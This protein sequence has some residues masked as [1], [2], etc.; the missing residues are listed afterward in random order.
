MLILCLVPVWSVTFFVT[1]DGPCHL[2]N[3]KILLDWFNGHNRAFYDPFYFINTNF[4]PNWLFNLITFPLVGFLGPATTD[5]FFFTLYVAGFG[6]GFRFLINQMNPEAKFISTIGLLFC[7]HKLL[8]TGFL[9]NSL[10]I[11][12]WFWVAGWWWKNRNADGYG[13]ILIQALLFLVL[14]SSHPV[15]YI[16][17]IV[18]ILSMQTGLWFYERKISSREHA[19]IFL[20]KRIITTFLSLLPSLVLFF[21]YMFRGSW[22]SADIQHSMTETIK[23]V[24]LLKSL[25]TIHSLEEL[26][27]LLTSILTLTLFLAAIWIRIKAKKW[28]AADGLI[29]FVAFVLWSILFPPLSLTGGLEISFRLAIIPFIAILFWTATANF[30]KWVKLATQCAALAIAVFFL[31][32]RI[33]VHKNASDYAKEIYTASPH[34]R[35]TSTLLVLNYDWA[36]QTPEGKPISD[37]AWMFIHVDCYLGTEKSLVISDNYETHFPYFP[38]IARWNTDMYQQTDKD[39]INFDH[40][41][42]RADILD[43]NRRTQQHLDYVLLISYRDEFAAHP[44]T[45]EIFAQLAQGYEKIFESSYRRAILYRRNGLVVK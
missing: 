7:F 9:N 13:P 11:V 28:V 44:Y 29:L 24:A 32:V 25:V 26:P 18:M 21:E 30:P 14:Y 2:Y 33:P 45:Q 23:N 5:K 20:Q 16:F 31:F 38:V 39:R 12:L 4:D 36:G 10:S 8:M 19:N 27:A 37:R 22:T 40:R 1:G 34:I 41:P 17:S 6:F 35:D 42:P 43:Y 15:G 3:S